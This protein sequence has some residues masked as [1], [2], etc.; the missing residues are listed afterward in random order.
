M[1]ELRGGPGG[2][3]NGGQRVAVRDG[4][5]CYFQLLFFFFFGLLQLERKE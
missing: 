5:V 4:K 3:R 2:S 1:P